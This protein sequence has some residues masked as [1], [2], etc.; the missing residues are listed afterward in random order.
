[1]L[2]HCLNFVPGNACLTGEHWGFAMIYE[3][4]EY[5]ALYRKVGRA[6]KRPDCAKYLRKDAA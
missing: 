4:K 6:L 2:G 5:K 3:T 1:M